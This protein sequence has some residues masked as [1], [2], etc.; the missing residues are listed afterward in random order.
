ML[1]STRLCKS[2]CGALP[3]AKSAVVRSGAQKS[4]T[5]AKPSLAASFRARTLHT[6]AI[7]LKNVAILEPIRA[8]EPE[9]MLDGEIVPQSRLN[10]ILA[11]LG[12]DDEIPV[13]QETKME[14]EPFIVNEVL[15]VGRHTKILPGTCSIEERLEECKFCPPLF[16]PFRILLLFWNL[17]LVT[18][19]AQGSLVLGHRVHWT[20]VRY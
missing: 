14:L 13:L 9:L 17:A 18:L 5:P 19:H 1:A 6:S 12:E 10:D 16:G 15:D 20:I 3:R 2:V 7:T 11:H 8:P 4:V